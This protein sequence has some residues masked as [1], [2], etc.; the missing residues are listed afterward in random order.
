MSLQSKHVFVTLSAL[1]KKPEFTG[2]KKNSQIF[3]RLL[4]TFIIYHYAV[5]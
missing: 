4:A 3:Y 5:Q 2:N 1:E